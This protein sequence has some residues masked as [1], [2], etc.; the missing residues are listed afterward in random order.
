M[1]TILQTWEMLSPAA[2]Q[3]KGGRYAGANSALLTA[4]R[5]YRPNDA[6][7]KQYLDQFARSRDAPPGVNS[8]M[9]SETQLT[10]WT[11]FNSEAKHNT[12]DIETAQLGSI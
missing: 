2:E 9:F 5:K 4:A 7:H 3:K 11:A 1:A 10:D 6:W 12:S 8:V